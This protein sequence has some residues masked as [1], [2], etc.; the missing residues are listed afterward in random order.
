MTG[1]GFFASQVLIAQFTTPPPK[2][3][4]PNDNPKPQPSPKTAASPPATQPASPAPSPSPSISP[5]PQASGYKA[6]IVLDNGLNVR[7]Q[8]NAE[9]SRIA[10]VDYDQQVTVLEESPDKE[11]QKIRTE[12]DGV[13]GWIKSGYTERLN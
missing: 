12:P 9:S 4:F 10:G 13:V 7:E 1:L 11:W 6:R 3:I 5:S 2:P 8:P